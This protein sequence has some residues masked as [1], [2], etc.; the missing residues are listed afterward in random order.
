MVDFTRNVRLNGL[1]T[2]AHKE[3]V[4]DYDETMKLN[5][6]LKIKINQLIEEH[7]I[8]KKDF[9]LRYLSLFIALNTGMR[10]GEIV[11]LTKNDIDFSK[12]LVNID[13]TWGYK[14]NMDRGFNPTKTKENR[15]I[16]V[17]IGTIGVFPI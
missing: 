17:G 9:D 7:K 13:K 1:D 5:S 15:I 16:K 11:G 8:I 6:Y 10:F 4:L 3:F 14:S 2:N 12:Q